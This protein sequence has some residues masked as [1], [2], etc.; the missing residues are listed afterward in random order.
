MDRESAGATAG[1]LRRLA[2]LLYDLLLTAAL[3]FAA[4]FLVLPLT[5]GEAVPPANQGAAA[6]GYRAWLL[7]VAFGYFGHSWTRG[8]TLGMAAWR[9]RLTTPGGG[10]PGWRAALLRYA[11]GALI[12]CSAA[13][14]T[15]YLGAGGSPLV[16]ASGGALL[17][18]LV[19]NYAAI[20]T[21][22]AR[23]T[24]Q[25]RLCGMRMVRG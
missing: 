16:A 10:P 3:L 2:A 1:I 22:G 7:L 5:G 8:R 12:A 6:Y 21:D 13:L 11:I 15:W 18:P 14:G 24:L 17:L 9:L 4:G 20:A 25:D 19:A 23:R